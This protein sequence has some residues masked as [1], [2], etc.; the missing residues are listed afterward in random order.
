MKKLKHKNLAIGMFCA[1][2]ASFILSISGLIFGIIQDFQKPTIV[3]DQIGSSKDYGLIKGMINGKDLNSLVIFK[4][5]KYIFSKDH[6]DAFS[7]YMFD[8]AIGYST[9]PFKKINEYDEYQINYELN[10]LNDKICYNLKLYNQKTNKK[11]EFN[12]LIKLV[13]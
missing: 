5:N 10:K 13:Q 11:Y 8:K 2:A 9:L 6:I 1:I 3:L 7:L 12:F 4:D